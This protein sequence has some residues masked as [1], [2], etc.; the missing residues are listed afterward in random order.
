ME[1][2]GVLENLGLRKKEGRLTADA[3]RS[4]LS[5]KSAC[6]HGG[7]R[8]DAPSNEDGAGRSKV[9][10]CPQSIVCWVVQ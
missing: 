7:K 4:L 8:R 5:L 2:I 10:R 1:V 9:S 6:T 3:V